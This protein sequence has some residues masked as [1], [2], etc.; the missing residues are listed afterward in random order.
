MFIVNETAHEK[1]EIRKIKR[2]ENKKIHVRKIPSFTFHA[3]P[4]K[5]HVF[6]ENFAP[7]Y[8]TLFTLIL[9]A[10]MQPNELFVLNFLKNMSQKL[11]WPG[12]WYSSE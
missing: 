2:L 4:V 11:E 6:Y 3:I 5:F 9:L 7:R 10:N 1:S 8:S 12:Q